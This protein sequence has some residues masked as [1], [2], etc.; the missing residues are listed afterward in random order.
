MTQEQLAMLLG[1]SRQA[2]SKWEA[3]KAYPEMDKLLKICDLFKCSLDDL[4]KGDLTHLPSDAAQSLPAD[5]RATDICGYDE[6]M[7]EFSLKISLGI[8]LILF[9][10]A[11][12]AFF[13]KDSMSAG[14]DPSALSVVSLFI[15]IA[16]GL[17]LII[18][19][20]VENNAFR[21]DHPFIENF[22]TAEQCR[23][24][25]K[26]FTT[27]LVSGITLIFMGI[28]SAVILQ[29]NESLSGAVFLMFT[30]FGVF[31]IVYGSLMGNRSDLDA[32]NR[33]SLRDLSDEKIAELSPDKQ[34]QVR[35]TKKSE[36]LYG[37]I[38]MIATALGLL[39]LFVPA[40]HAQSFFW[41]TWPIGGILCGAIAAF[42]GETR[43]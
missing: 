24:N 28:V 2:V 6:M 10:V 13:G 11:G 4:V 27:C 41:L 22:Y 30:A 36:G 15:G 42:R 18:P 20:G 21:H 17:A 33:E 43:R 9:G 1:V 14:A 29:E 31:L 7:R 38:M 37:G 23:K 3:E 8:A 25:R 5:A 40:F 34:E 12:A 16:A 19:A 26:L 32:Y 39:L 35:A